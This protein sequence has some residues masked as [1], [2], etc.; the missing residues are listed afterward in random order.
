MGIVRL[1]ER[2][3]SMEPERKPRKVL[4]DETPSP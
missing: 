1:I 2:R 3:E 4:F